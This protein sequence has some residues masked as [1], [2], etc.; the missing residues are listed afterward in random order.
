MAPREISFSGVVEVDETYLGGSWRNRR[1]AKRVQGT[2]RGRGTTKQAVF[3]ILCRG[4]LVWA[5]VVPNVEAKTLLPLLHQRVQWL[6]LLPFTLAAYVHRL[7]ARR[8]AIG[9]GATSTV[10]SASGSQRGSS[11][12]SCC[13]GRHWQAIVVAGLTIP[14]LCLAKLLVVAA[15]FGTAALA[16][17]RPHYPYVVT[18]P[19]EIFT[20][21]G[22]GLTGPFGGIVI[23]ILAGIREPGGIVLA[24]LL[25]HV[26]GGLWMGLSYKKLVREHT[27]MPF[28]VLGWA[29]IVLLY[30]YVFV[31]PGFVIGLHL[32]Y[33]AVYA[34][35]YGE[36]ASLIRAYG[37]L[38]IGHGERGTGALPEALLTALI[39]TL[40][41][42]AL[43]RRHR[44]PLW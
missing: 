43:P 20:T 40:A 37:E 35:E 33:P 41:F 5:Q 42:V 7:E 27:Q 8:S 2:K 11:P 18:D 34:E 12:L 28:S 32:F 39:T 4:G 15:V 13:G 30:Y 26:S 22:A 36:G 14:S 29:A 3:G 38:G 25:A 24:S 17:W 16:I 10:A 1:L 23:G 9:K 21:T 19:R 6:Q 31:V 44:R